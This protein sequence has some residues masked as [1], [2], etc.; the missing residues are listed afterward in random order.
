MLATTLLTT[1]SFLAHT[2]KT[3]STFHL[4]LYIQ[5]YLLSIFQDLIMLELVIQVTLVGVTLIKHRLQKFVEIPYYGGL[6][7]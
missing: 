5:K 6:G 4:Y 2:T 1:S 7:A 3:E